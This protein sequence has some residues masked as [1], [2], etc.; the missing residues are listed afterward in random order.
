M[1]R[2]KAYERESKTKEFSNEGLRLKMK[3]ARLAKQQRQQLLDW[4]D[5]VVP[6]LSEQI[7]KVE[8]EIKDLEGK[9][10][11]DPDEL[12]ADALRIADLDEKIERLKAHLEHCSKL[13]I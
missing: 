1:E 12:E 2:Y 13:V 4:L 7:A 11:D 3:S 8:G 6:M 10:T 5:E 9:E